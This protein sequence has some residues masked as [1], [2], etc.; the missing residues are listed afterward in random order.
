MLSAAPLGSATRAHG[1]AFSMLFFGYLELSTWILSRASVGESHEAGLIPL[2]YSI[3]TYFVAAWCAFST[4]TGLPKQSN[5]SGWLNQKCYPH[6]RP[7]ATLHTRTDPIHLPLSR[8][9]GT[10]LPVRARVRAITTNIDSEAVEEGQRYRARHRTSGGRVMSV[11][12]L[13]GQAKPGQVKMRAITGRM[14]RKRL[15]SW[16]SLGRK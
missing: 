14:K 13:I 5:R 12:N 1:Y 4:G 7:R 9:R 10:T 11:G 6:P 2:H 3:A 15:E 16:M 8:A